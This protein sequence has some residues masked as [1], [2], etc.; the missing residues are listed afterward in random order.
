MSSNIYVNGEYLKKN[1]EYHLSD[2]EWKAKYILNLIQKHELIPK[3]I[4][5]FGSGSGDILKNVKQGLRTIEKG[6]GYDLSSDAIRIA[7][8]RKEEGLF[9]TSD[10]LKALDT[11]YDLLL[12]IDVVEHV[13]CYIDFLKKLKKYSKYKIFHFPLDMNTLMVLRNTPIIHSRFQYGH[14]HYFSKDTVLE[15][16]RYCGYDII[17]WFYTPTMYH[18]NTKLFTKMLNPIRSLLNLFNEDLSVR[19]LGGRSI[20]LLAI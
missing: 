10:F 18:N 13:D 19:L 2:A 15:T 7:I 20:I 17:D 5:D 3:T 11:Y 9:F 14:L 1:P 6:V 12:C 16:L 4:L 8:S